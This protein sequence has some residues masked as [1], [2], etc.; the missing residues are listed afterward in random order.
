[1]V[2][3]LIYAVAQSN[4][5]HKF[6]FLTQPFLT[7]LLSDPPTNLEAMA[8]DIKREEKN[9]P[10]LVRYADR[11]RREGFDAVVDLHNVLRTRFLR[12]SLW[13]S[14]VRTACIHKPRKA[15]RRLVA[16]PPK[17]VLQPLPHMLQLEREA[18][19][20]V[21]LHVPQEISPIRIS[22]QAVRSFFEL[23]PEV[24]A[25]LDGTPLIGIAPF[26]ST[27]AKTYSLEQMEEVV[28]RLSRET[29]YRVLLFGAR[30]REAELLSTWQ[31]KYQH[32][33]SLAGRLELSQEIALIS[34]L[35]C[36]VSMDSAN[37]HFASMVGVRVLSLW[38]A[39][40]PYAGF[41]GL[42]QRQEDCLQ[43]ELDCRPCSTFGQVK[44]CLHGDYR[45]RTMISSDTIYRHIIQIINQH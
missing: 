32:V 22:N 38:C 5:E 9:I 33:H 36:M 20:R 13:F 11:L 1:M 27:H 14:G 6:T 30:G 16:A 7:A 28:S 39:T 19:E 2:V 10:G 8:I 3:P 45:C 44:R 35:I 24:S 37:A 26:A 12:Y 29:N 15:R 31:G 17:K 25:L 41:L 18:L 40:H 43:P 23:S 4:P 21:G 34:Q 42:G